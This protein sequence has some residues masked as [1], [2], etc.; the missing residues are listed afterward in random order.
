MCI[1]NTGYTSK[2]V[3]WIA[4]GYGAPCVFDCEYVKI[5]KTD[6]H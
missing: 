3:N 5:I 4:L 6:Y 1:W 2:Y